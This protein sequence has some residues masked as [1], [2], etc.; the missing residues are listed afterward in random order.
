MTKT[1]ELLPLSVSLS[2]L[3][4]CCFVF[5]ATSVYLFWM[6]VCV[7]KC[8]LSV[9][10]HWYVGHLRVRL[11]RVAKSLYKSLYKSLFKSLYPKSIHWLCLCLFPVTQISYSAPPSSLLLCS[12]PSVLSRCFLSFLL[13]LLIVFPS[14]LSLSPPVA[15]VVEF[16]LMRIYLL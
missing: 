3:C 6:S 10:G 7:C 12:F 8:A 15:F 5:L 16:M 14:P 1:D 11:P 4:L 2:P 13:R 9:S